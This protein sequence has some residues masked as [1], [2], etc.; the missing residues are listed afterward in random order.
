ME[1][2]KEKRGREREERKGCSVAN[3]G[4]LGVSKNVWR[5]REKFYC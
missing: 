1:G 3:K 5:M 2:G 4:E